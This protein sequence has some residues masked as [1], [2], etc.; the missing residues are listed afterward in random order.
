[1]AKVDGLNNPSYEMTLTTQLP[2]SHTED[3]LAYDVVN[4]PSQKVP[5]ITIT[6][7]GQTY[8]KLCH[9]REENG[10]LSV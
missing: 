4:L 6:G 3:T 1:M 7:N 8:D 5:G 10:K 9:T 2:L